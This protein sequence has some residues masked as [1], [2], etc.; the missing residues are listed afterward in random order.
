[1]D[2]DSEWMEI[3]NLPKLIEFSRKLIYSNFDG[4]N[5]SLTD[6]DFLTKVEKLHLSEDE[7]KELEQLLPLKEC[8][9]I[10]YD[11]IRIENN[12]GKRE[13]FMEEGSFDIIL[14]QLN[15]RMISNIVQ[16]LVKQGHLE[17]AF[18]NEKNDFVFWVS[19][20]DDNETEED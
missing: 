10:F 7:N 11:F 12:Q 4:T 8:E 2:K 3:V 14:V 19:R 20:D 13:M 17:T 9:I 6:Q 5:D 1:M 15:S 16:N 18:D